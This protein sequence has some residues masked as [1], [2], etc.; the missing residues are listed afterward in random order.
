[1]AKNGSSS[2]SSKSAARPRENFIPLP[3]CELLEAFASEL[4]GTAID[5]VRLDHLCQLL[6]SVV[7][8]EF[9]RTATALKDAYVPFD[10][11]ADTHSLRAFDSA[12]EQRA[13]EAICGRLQDLLEQANFRRLSPKEIDA[14]LLGL[15]EWGVNLQV[16]F[17][18]FER[19]DVFARGDVNASR[20]RRRWR[21]ML[22]SEAVQVPV[23]QRLVVVFRL[24]SPDGAPPPGHAAQPL[25]VKLFKDIPQSD[26]ESL[27]PGASVC[28]TWFDRGRILVPTLS[29]L[30]LTLVKLMQ[31]AVGMV[32]A[33][34]YGMLAFVGLVIG[35]LG[36]GVKAF[37]GYL[38]TRN[39]YQLYLTRNLYF[40][41]LDNNRGALVR[42][43]D[44]AEEQ[45]LREVLLGYFLLWRDAPTQ[46]WTATE[47]DHAAERWLRERVQ[48][49]VDFEISDALAKLARLGLANQ[50]ADERWHAAP[51]DEAH[52]Q[53]VQRWQA[54]L[55]WPTAAIERQAPPPP[56]GTLVRPAV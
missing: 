35:T 29:G 33:G 23:Y 8:R 7:H 44:E 55:A 49:S 6:T 18:C 37:F 2:A 19:L 28:M 46:G 1:M 34:I 4:A 27:L 40:Q 14:A 11:D 56:H 42:L 48:T 38:Q 52:R 26:I 3:A 41:N 12:R 47:L 54:V 50:D 53:L 30:A 51:L 20:R 17:S 16:D 24:R 22:R 45:E 39:K 36:Y 9:Q 13:Y 32:F 43:V 21:R 5:R 10:P 25:Y 31:G 15:N